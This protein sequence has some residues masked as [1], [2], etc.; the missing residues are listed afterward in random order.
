MQ[1]DKRCVLAYTSMYIE[2]DGKIRPCC[3]A[4]DFEDELN[5]NDYDTIPEIYNSPQM[6]SLRKSMEAGDPL[7]VCV[8]CFKGNK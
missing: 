5:F 7:S 2:P 1:K 3:I 8:I 4:G 6:R